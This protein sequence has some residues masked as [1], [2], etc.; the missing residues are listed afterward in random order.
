[1]AN[2]IPQQ[3]CLCN[4]KIITKFDIDSKRTSSQIDTLLNNV[5]KQSYQRIPFKKKMRS[6]CGQYKKQDGSHIYFMVANLTFM[7]GKEGQHPKDL[8]RIQYNIEWR[9][10]YEQYAPKGE[11][12]WLG[13]YSYCDSNIWSFF[14]PETYLQKHE[15]KSMTSKGGHKA[16]YSCH[17]YLNDLKIG[18]ENGECHSFH[19]KMDKNGNTVGAI[20]NDCLADFFEGRL[21]KENPILRKIQEINRKSIKWNEWIR[22]DQAIPYMKSLSATTGFNK[23]KE[24]LWNGWYIEGIYSDHLSKYPSD[25]ISYIATTHDNSIRSEYSQFKLDLGFPN[26]Q[27]H[28]IGDLKAI[29]FED[30]MVQ[31][32]H[33]GYDDITMSIAGE[34][35]LNDEKCINKALKKYKKIWFVIYIHDK[36][37]GNTDNYSMVKWRNNFILESN[38]LD[39]NKK[40]NPLSARNTPHSVAYTEMVIIELNDITKGTYF[41]LK[42]QGRN[43]NG[44]VRNKKYAISKK[45][46]REITDDSFVIAR[47]RVN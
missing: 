40:Y 33:H 27:Y 6:I 20:R 10:F 35:Y 44:N 45:F 1:M 42:K 37:K 24:N 4:N 36:K 14:K 31:F 18:H 13:L 25:Y 16:M 7:G 23:W 32:C 41:K 5:L 30:D 9:N 38:E 46:L 15:G 2:V 22:A 17:I 47:Y 39:I 21:D 28:F 26:K 12:F 19:V 43:S 34:S 3:L 29:S 11:V 8:K